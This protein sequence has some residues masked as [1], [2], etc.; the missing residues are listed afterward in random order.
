MK[1]FE[2]PRENVQPNLATKDGELVREL[3]RMRILMER[4]AEKAEG[5]EEVRGREDEG[6]EMMGV[7][8]RLAAMFDAEVMET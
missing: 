8:D 1:P 7:E 5:M 6:D 4:V 3:E 2:H